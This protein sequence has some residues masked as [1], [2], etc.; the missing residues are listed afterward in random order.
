MWQAHFTDNRLLLL[1]RRRGCPRKAKGWRT[2]V[3]E[4]WSGGDRRIKVRKGRHRGRRDLRE[5][6]RDRKMDER[7]RGARLLPCLG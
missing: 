4:K 2:G 7:R 5:M 3:E 1:E 6:K